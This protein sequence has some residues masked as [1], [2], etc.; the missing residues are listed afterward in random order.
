MAQEAPLNGMAPLFNLM[1][2]NSTELYIN[3][4]ELS[5]QFCLIRSFKMLVFIAGQSLWK[6]QLHSTLQGY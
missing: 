3:S 6:C 1:I 5:S 2:I 4:S